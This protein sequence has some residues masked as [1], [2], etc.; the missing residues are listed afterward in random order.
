MSWYCVLPFRHAF[1]DSTGV[2]AC[3]NTRRYPVGLDQWEEHPNLKLLQQEL[4]TG[5]P[6]DQCRSCVRQEQTQGRSL[7]TDSNLDYKNQVFTDT[8]IDFV[9]YRSSNI[10]N[11]KC[12][13]C[14]P[15]FSH[16]IAQEAR[17]HESLATF[18]KSLDSKTVS[19]TDDNQEWVIDHLDQINRLMITGGEPTVI[20]GI[21]NII[22]KIIQG[23][24]KHLQLLITTNASFTD[25]FWYE[26]TD[27]V[28]NLHWTVSVDAV[29][30]AAEIIRHGTDWSVVE[31][32]VKWLAQHANSL[33]INTVV[34]NLNV[35]QLAPLLK[36]GREMQQL[37]ITP[38]G[39]H[40][41]IGCRHQFYVIQRPNYLSADNWPN[42]MKLHVVKY[43][44]NCLTLDLD[45][46]QQNAV[47][48][49]LNQIQNSQFDSNLW[50]RTQEYNS[51]LNNIRDQNHTK[52]YEQDMI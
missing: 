19:I 3:C 4:L 9:D 25:D 35:L 7:R 12:R 20:P 21:K 42:D 32:N 8:K 52:L 48:G 5:T 33:D 44:E 13:S 40:G 39:R 11:F 47:S 29:G 36:F 17:L 34:T 30:A 16:G 38:S 45:S 46:E 22:E 27:K 26:L 50:E 1:V 41:S 31:R 28:S 51:I 2:G 15:V 18:Y 23:Q 24:Y 6:P 37:S 10:C 49:L 14:M 43:L